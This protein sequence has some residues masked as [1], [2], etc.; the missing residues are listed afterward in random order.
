MT[1]MI[2]LKRGDGHQLGAAQ[3]AKGA[4]SVSTKEGDAERGTLGSILGVPRVGRW[5]DRWLLV[6]VEC[7]KGR[8]FQR[9]SVPGTQHLVERYHYGPVN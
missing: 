6:A 2:D 3:D 4:R 7:V 5:T 8:D 1:Y 9:E